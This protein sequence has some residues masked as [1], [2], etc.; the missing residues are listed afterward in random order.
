MV[1]Q[2]I[3]SPTPA[4]LAYARRLI[5][6]HGYPT[7]TVAIEDISRAGQ[8]CSDDAPPAIVRRAYLSDKQLFDE[9]N[10]QEMWNLIA[11]LKS[12]SAYGITT[13]RQKT[14][15]LRMIEHHGFETSADAIEAIS[16]VAEECPSDVQAIVVR[17]A[18][19]SGKILLAELDPDEMANLVAV[20]DR[21]SVHG[22]STPT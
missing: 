22:L 3:S 15:A 19:D 10:K 18:R 5:E 17:C 2:R 11:T 16:R 6:R 13:P 1:G 4:Q 7:S 14:H 12:P 21:P 8:E 9:L 20:L